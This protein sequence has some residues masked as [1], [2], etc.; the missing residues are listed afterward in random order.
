MKYIVCQGCPASGK[1]TWAKEHAAL[2]MSFRINRDETRRRIFKFEKWEDYT[3]TKEDEDKVTEANDRLLLAASQMEFDV[4]DDNTNLVLKY[5][6]E[7]LKKAKGLGYEIEYKQFF[8]VPLDELIR[9]DAAR[10][11]SVGE[12][13]MH[14][15]WENQQQLRGLK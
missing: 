9:R 7:T 2:S 13:V 12:E 14:K 10:E 5:L 15:M 11:H 8:D 1:T 3:F 4:I 6:N